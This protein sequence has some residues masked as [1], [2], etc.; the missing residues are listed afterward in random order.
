LSKIEWH[1]FTGCVNLKKVSIPVSVTK[2]VGESFFG[3][4]RLEHIYYGG[5]M[6]QWKA[7]DKDK[8]LMHSW[9]KNTGKYVVH[10]TD[11][12]LKK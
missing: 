8:S 10:C 6:K 4:M 1:T 5:T 7:I 2:I 11:G 3:C 12:D 9:N